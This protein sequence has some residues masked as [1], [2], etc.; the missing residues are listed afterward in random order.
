STAVRRRSRSTD[1]ASCMA[2]PLSIVI[3]GAS[4]D[5]TGRKLIPALFQLHAKKRLPADTRIV[6]VAR[7]A[8]SDAQFHAELLGHA[9]EV[10]PKLDPAA[11]Q[12]FFRRVHYV[13]ADAGAAGG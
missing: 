5:L 6:G 11:W 1:G 12:E 13:R 3:F 4:G 9:R 10:E 2:L 7:S 8:F